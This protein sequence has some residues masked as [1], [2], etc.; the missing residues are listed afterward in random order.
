MS[1][2]FYYVLLLFVMPVFVQAQ[3]IGTTGEK[4][5]LYIKEVVIIASRFQERKEDVSQQVELVHANRL[6]QLN[7][8]STADVLQQTPGILVQK[9]QI[10][11]I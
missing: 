8:A 1:T 4:D 3:I 6:Q 9:S 10:I 2:N 11:K 5:T 7:A